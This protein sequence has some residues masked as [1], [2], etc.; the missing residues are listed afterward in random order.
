MMDVKDAFKKGVILLKKKQRDEMTVGVRGK[1]DENLS[2]K[3]KP[4]TL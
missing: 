3:G 1:A 2:L 4:G